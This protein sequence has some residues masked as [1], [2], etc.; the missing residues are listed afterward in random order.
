MDK[1]CLPRS[2]WCTI[3]D[4]SDISLSIY[5]TVSNRRNLTHVLFHLK[6]GGLQ[7]R[8]QQMVPIVGDALHYD[9]ILYL[10]A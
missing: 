1:R 7:Q 6:S 5:F 2:V 3:R 4:I 9:R 10:V 8:P